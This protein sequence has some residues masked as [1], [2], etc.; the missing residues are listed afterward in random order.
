MLK[1]F[2]CVCVWK[3]FEKAL[4]FVLLMRREAF[5]S[6]DAIVWPDSQTL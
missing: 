5:S 2:V 6:W 3:S 4:K 1:D